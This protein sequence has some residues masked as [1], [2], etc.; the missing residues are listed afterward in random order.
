MWYALVVWFA[1]GEPITHPIEPITFDT[2]AECIEYVVENTE[3]NTLM[4]ED[5]S[6]TILDDGIEDD[7]AAVCI[8][9]TTEA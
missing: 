2:R 8:T 9:R 4:F 7:F 1:M 3:F 6:R 5:W